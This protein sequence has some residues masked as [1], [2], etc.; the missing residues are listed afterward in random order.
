[1][2]FD[3]IVVLGCRVDGPETLSGA[4][5]RRVTRAARAYRE[6]MATH[7]VASGGKRWGEAIEARAM[8]AQ[9]QALGVPNA[10]ILHEERSLTT[11]QNARFVAELA[12]ARGLR[13]LGIV[14]CDWHMRRAMAAFRRE[15]FEV[16]PL[17]A[18][19]PTLPLTARVRRAGLERLRALLDRAVAA[20]RLEIP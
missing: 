5:L 8:A 19:A 2:G 6:G 15:G 4:A 10:R 7:V 18:P 20:L 11:V 16:H 3:A 12:R 14:T 9:L 17:P 1:M 13:S